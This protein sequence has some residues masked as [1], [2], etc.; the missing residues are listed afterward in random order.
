MRP[1]WVEFLEKFET[2]LWKLPL[3]VILRAYTNYLL[4]SEEVAKKIINEW[5][6]EH[7]G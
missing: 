6:E 7:L 1:A 5:E 2:H 3:F 4:D